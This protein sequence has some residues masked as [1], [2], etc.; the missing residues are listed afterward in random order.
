[1]KRFIKAFGRFIRI[2]LT[3]IAVI[4]IVVGCLGWGYSHV[5]NWSPA[6]AKALITALLFAVL[7]VLIKVMIKRGRNY[8]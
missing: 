3:V 8:D 4:M 1:M 7:L 2:F 5:A 6:V